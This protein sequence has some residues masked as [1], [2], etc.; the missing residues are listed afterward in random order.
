M[1]YDYVLPNSLF[2][3]LNS[4]RDVE[5]KVY[6]ETKLKFDFSTYFVQ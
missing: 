5:S 4:R 6:G 1:K 2:N 3:K